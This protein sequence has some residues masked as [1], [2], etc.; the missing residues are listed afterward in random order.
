MS[1]GSPRRRPA[2]AAA[3]VA[4]A[5]AIGLAV[6]WAGGQGAATTFGW[7]T[8]VVCVAVAFAMQWIAFVPAFIAQTERFYD[9]T[10]SLTY[11]TVIGLALWS[12]GITLHGALLAGAVCV[13]AI[14]LGTFLFMRV[15]ADGGDGRFDAIKPNGPRFLVAWTLQGLWVSLTAAAALAGITAPAA[16]PG[17]LAWIGLAVF[18]FGFAIEVIADAQKRRH[19][20]R[21]PG[22]FITEGL[23]AWSRHPNYFGEIVLWVGIA[24]LAA[25]VLRGWQYVTLISPLLVYLLLTRV[26]GIPLLEKRADDRWGDEP[27]YTAW[28]DRTPALFPRPPRG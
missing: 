20:A 3:V 5:V 13:W 22:R 14:R 4:V 9:L 17:P 21:S 26:S 23:W 18:A 27:A 7:P 16:A 2:V 10:G 19:R 8:P 24:L 25:D 11:L 15:H 1:D 12:A 6:A 28:R